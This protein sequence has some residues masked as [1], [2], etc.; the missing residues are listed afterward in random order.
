MTDSF[1]RIVAWNVN[2]LA[3]RCHELETFLSY[4]KIDIALISE[5]HCTNRS[6]VKMPGYAVYH[7][8]HPSGNAHAGTAIFVK[9]N[10]RHFVQEEICFDY[11]QGTV[12]T[13]THNGAKLS[14]VAA[15]RPPRHSVVSQQF[16]AIF[17]KLG[18]RFIIGGDFNAKHEAWGSRLTRTD[19]R[20]L[21][22]AINTKSCSFLSARKPTYWPAD[23][24]KVPDLLDFFITKGI[25]NSYMDVENVEDL[26]SDHTPLLLT[27][28]STVTK[29]RKRVTLTNKCTNWET[30]RDELDQIIELKVR[31]KTTQELDNQAQH[32]IDAIRKAASLATPVPK[33]DTVQDVCYPLE[34]RNLIVERRRARRTWNQ[35]RYPG[36]K[37]I[38]NRISNKLNRLI[39]DIKRESFEDRL[40]NLSADAD[41]DY[42]LWKATRRLKRPIQQVPPLKYN[43][44]WLRRDEEK[45]ELFAEHLESV[46]QPHPIQSEIKPVKHYQETQP[47]SPVTPYEVAQEIDNNINS[48]KAPGIDEISP[49]VLKE[50]SRKGI[51]F[52]TYIFNACLRLEHVP[53]CFKTAQII[54][55]KKPDK[56]ANEVTSYRPISLLSAISKL[57]EKLLLK[58]L[59]P[60]VDLPE[61]QFG[62]RSHHSTIDQI[63]RV[64]S[65]IEKALEEKKYCSAVLI[66]I[67]QA[68]DRVWHAGLISKL[69]KLLPGN[70]CRLI[71]S[72]LADRTF[73]VA[74][75]E[76]KSSFRQISAGV[77]QGSV[78]G[79]ILY[80]LY[81]AD[82][83]V[84][85]NTTTATFAD[86]TA[87]L[88]VSDS[89]VKATENL[90]IALNHVNCWTQDWKIKL[91]ESKSVH[92]TYTLRK[93]D[94]NLRVYLNNTQVPQANSAKYLGMHLDSRLNWKL[95]VEKKVA[96]VKLK[97]RQLY[98]LIGRHSQ[99]DL[100]CKCLLYKQ[101]I[102]PIWTYGIQIWGCTAKSNRE[103]I[104][105]RQNLILRAITNA[106]QYVRNSELHSDLQIQWVRDVIRDFAI[107]HEE[108]LHAHVNSEVIQLLDTNHDI[109]RLKRKKPQDLVTCN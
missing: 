36:D 63:H 87:I 101:I 93:V 33:S 8:L 17:D 92:V 47:F 61:H 74:H 41:K 5:T 91:N 100:Y 69:S 59:K 107:A 97:I 98:W 58:R 60:L 39:K 105:A 56:P 67:S 40:A 65:I 30:F 44:R 85:G 51:V 64:T 82:L 4:N 32:L 3:R 13:V 35:T 7:T 88:S 18:P 48:K 109:R 73:S 15:Y 86:D 104:Q 71:E 79:P 81:T 57:F 29:K 6:Y 43:G 90:Q 96:Q 102:R 1:L 28:S 62:F 103:K 19:G 11:F 83:P 34:V 14:L 45:A 55:I 52:L 54:M 26:T 9:Q 10:I 77:P 84:D 53:F 75:E 95:H 37:T 108:R 12:I 25:A 89:H 23:I 20:M 21:L 50:L 46:F 24:R 68:F 80:L 76:A 72:Y 78:L 99:L 38:F 27:I 49:G 31:L 16:E 94:T 22:Q 106:R 70:Y 2:G 42:S 66:D